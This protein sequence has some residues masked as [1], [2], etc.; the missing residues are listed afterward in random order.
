ML[1][2]FLELDCRTLNVLSLRSSSSDLLGELDLPSLPLFFSIVADLHMFSSL[3]SVGKT[4]LSKALAG[5]LFDDE[6]N[7]L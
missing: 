4:E 7:A 5:F 6:K 1:F 2:D 3:C